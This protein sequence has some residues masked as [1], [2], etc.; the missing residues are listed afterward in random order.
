MKVEFT[1]SLLTD[2]EKV[3]PEILYVVV[4][5]KKLKRSA[6]NIATYFLLIFFFKW[7]DDLNAYSAL[8]GILL[9]TLPKLKFS[10]N[11]IF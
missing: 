8:N 5:K 11:K 7:M 6:E 2:E 9:N 1:L 4:N 10:V 3:R